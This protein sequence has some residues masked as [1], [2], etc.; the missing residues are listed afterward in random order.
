MSGRTAAVA[1]MVEDGGPMAAGASAPVQKLNRFLLLDG[2][3]LASV[4]VQVGTS[5]PESVAWIG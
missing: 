3:E 4:D 5:W 1:I 2:N